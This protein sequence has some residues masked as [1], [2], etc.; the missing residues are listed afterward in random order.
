MERTDEQQLEHFDAAL[1]TL[2]ETIPNAAGDWN[3][4]AD[5]GDGYEIDVWDTEGEY[6]GRWF[7]TPDSAEKI[8]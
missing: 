2:M 1:E 7:A 5:A 3:V 8:S 6:L 4:K